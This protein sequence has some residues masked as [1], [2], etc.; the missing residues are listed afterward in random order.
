MVRLSNTDD[1]RKERDAAVTGL[2]PF[3]PQFPPDDPTEEEIQRHTDSCLRNWQKLLGPEL[4]EAEAMA[5]RYGI[6]L[7]ATAE[8]FVREWF[9][10]KVRV[11]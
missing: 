3:S 9:S 6:T 10:R 8:L 7:R 5:Q 4:A 2:A 11:L 1:V